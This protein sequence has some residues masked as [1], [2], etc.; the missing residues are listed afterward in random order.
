MHKLVSVFADCS[1]PKGLFSLKLEGLSLSEYRRLLNYCYNPAIV[2]EDLKKEEEKFSEGPFNL[3]KEDAQ[4][5][6]H[7]NLASSLIF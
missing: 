1:E 5:Q 4:I 7:K 3:S 6:L 2:W